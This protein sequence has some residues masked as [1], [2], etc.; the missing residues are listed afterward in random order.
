MNFRIR[1]Q[2]IIALR[3]ACAAIL[4]VD[5][6]VGPTILDEDIAKFLRHVSGQQLFCIGVVHIF[7]GCD[8][9]TIYIYIIIGNR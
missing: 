3:E 2:A 8:N 7:C 4:V 6:Q 5:G 1:D 9:D